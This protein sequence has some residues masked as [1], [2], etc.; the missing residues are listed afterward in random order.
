MEIWNF[1]NQQL[2]E[3][4]KVMLIVVIDRKGSSPG[5]VGF[6]MAISENDSLS[7]SIGGGIMEYNMAELAK[8]LIKTP[9]PEIFIKRQSHNPDDEKD[10]SG[11]ICTGE[12]TH[13]FFPF[14]ASFLPLIKQ[15]ITCIENGDKGEITI[16][17][18][19]F[20]FNEKINNNEPIKFQLIS[21]NQWE[22]SEQIGLKDT[23]Y[24]FGAGHVSIPLSQVFRMLGFKVE[25][26]D[27]RIDLSTFINNLSAHKKHIID[28]KNVSQL[29]PEGNNSY[30]VIMTMGHTFDE[31]VLKQMLPK[32]LKYLGMI[33]SK[34]KTKTIFDSLKNHGFINYDLEKVDAPIGISINSQTTAEIAISIAAKII[35]VKNSDINNKS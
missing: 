24:I 7:G 19:E 12:Q 21:E 5:K 14:D 28:Y 2:A 6:K 26:F 18:T 31:L 25:I 13:I 22:Y 15:I 9:K 3:K 33:G 16:S 27:N 8:K 1:I 35:Q 23:L 34:N 20:N 4:N 30:V 29:I 11:L 32:K 10:K 17:P